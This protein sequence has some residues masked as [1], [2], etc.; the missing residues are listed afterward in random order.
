MKRPIERARSAGFEPATYGSGG[1][2]SI[3]LSYERLLGRAVLAREERPC[4]AP[5]QSRNR[6]VGVTAN[7]SK[8]LFVAVRAE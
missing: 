5:P 2:R 7:A 4:K 3:Q 6:A 1:R 8:S